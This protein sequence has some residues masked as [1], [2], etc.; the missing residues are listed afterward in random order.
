M[1]RAVKAISRLWLRARL[2]VAG[3]LRDRSGIAATEFAV[4]VPMMLVMLF[5]TV[6]FS[7]GV[8]IDRKV[9]LIART[10]VDLTSQA[11]AVNDTDIANFRAA[12][13]AIMAPYVPPT[14]VAPNTTISEL[15]IDAVSGAARVQWSQG[16]APR[17]TSSTVAIP[18]SLIALDANGKIIPNQY[19]LYS[20]VNVLY[21][22]TMPFVTA[23]APAGVTLTDVAYTRPRQATCVFYPAAPAGNNPPCPTS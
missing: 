22:P 14:Y 5:S 1:S 4:I 7:I 2:S 18:P 9:T 15:Y 17:A 10:L 20:E 13:G 19:L 3:L 8:A 16:S 6:E 21:T 23:M 11:G 12:G